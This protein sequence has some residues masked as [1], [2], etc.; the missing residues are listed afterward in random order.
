MNHRNINK[1]ITK[2]YIADVKIH[3]NA[4]FEEDATMKNK[5]KTWEKMDFDTFE[6]TKSYSEIEN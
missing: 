5:H 6:R 2:L 1:W 4:R 3:K